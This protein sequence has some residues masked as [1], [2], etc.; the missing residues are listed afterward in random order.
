MHPQQQQQPPPH[1]HQQPPHPHGPPGPGGGGGAPNPPSRSLFVDFVPPGVSE[2]EVAHIFRPFA[3][4]QECRFVP[5]R[6]A[7][8]DPKTHLVFVDFATPQHAA[9]ALAQL[10]G[11]VFDAKDPQSPTLKLTYS[12][13][14]HKPW[15]GGP[16]DF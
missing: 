6:K 15:R 16:G 7:L 13:T 9:G 4:Y 8:D 14:A 1:H 3:G 5:I 12:R 11:Y 2:R 10:Q